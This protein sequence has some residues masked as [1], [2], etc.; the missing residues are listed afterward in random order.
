MAAYFNPVDM[1]GYSHEKEDSMKRILSL[2]LL[3]SLV[4][5]LTAC[6]KNDTT[7]EERVARAVSAIPS[8]VHVLAPNAKPEVTEA[9]DAAVSAYQTFFG[10]KTSDSWTKADNAWLAARKYL[11]SLN[12]E[13][14]NL[15]IAAVDI[16]RSQVI[17]PPI[18]ANSK[19]VAVVKTGFTEDAVRRL[20]KLTKEK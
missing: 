20:E 1:C 3:L 17:V 8:I 15:I 13:K 9:I 7:L 16:L 19:S 11:R 12:S 5:L 2:S 10:D 14:I 18:A 6:P 4:L